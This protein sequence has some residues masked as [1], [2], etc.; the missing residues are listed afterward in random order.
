MPGSEG[1]A[2]E[3]AVNGKIAVYLRDSGGAEY[4][5]GDRVL[6]GDRKRIGICMTADRCDF[7]SSDGRDDRVDHPGGAVHGERR[8]NRSSYTRRTWIR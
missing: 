5:I 1:G 2:V 8:W 7:D 6:V 4:N 3:S